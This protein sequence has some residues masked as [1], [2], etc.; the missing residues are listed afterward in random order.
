MKLRLRQGFLSGGVWG[1]A[2]LLL[3][4]LLLLTLGACAKHEPSSRAASDVDYYTCTMHPSVHS[5][6]PGKCPI[7]SMD[8]VPVKKQDAPPQQQAQTGS[9]ATA[10]APARGPAQ[11]TEFTVPVERQQQIGVTYA[12]VERRPLRFSI[13][14]VGVLEAETGKTFDYVA[15]V[16]GYVQELKVRSPGEWVSKGQPLMTVYS[17]DLRSTEQELVNLLDDRDRAGRPSPE[18]LI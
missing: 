14:S 6:D 11:S 17:P 10:A 18:P 3:L 1:A 4:L 7:C 8:L 15:R 12:A 16:D 13:R 9:P 2:L 5:K